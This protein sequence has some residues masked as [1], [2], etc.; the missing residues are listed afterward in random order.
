M[1]Y[2]KIIKTKT[3][4]IESTKFVKVKMQISLLQIVFTFTD[5]N[6]VQEGIIYCKALED[7]ERFM[8]AILS[9]YELS[10]KSTDE[11]I[12]YLRGYCRM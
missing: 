8:R 2:T 1:S 9:R 5:A 12:E 4:F 10:T 11:I 7:N 6:A 3:L